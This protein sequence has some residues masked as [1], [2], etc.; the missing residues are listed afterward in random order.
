MALRLYGRGRVVTFV[1]DALERDGVPERQVLPTLLLSGQHGSGGSAL[2]RRLGDEFG[3]DTLCAHLDLAGAQGAGDAVLAAAHCLHR[4]IRW[5]RRVEFPRLRILI[6]ALSFVDE[7]GIRGDFESYLAAE[8]PGSRSTLHTWLGRALDLV[9]A[10]PEPHGDEDRPGA[11]PD[12]DPD[13]AAKS[14]DREKSGRDKA[15]AADLAQTAAWILAGVNHREDQ[16]ALHWFAHS[17]IAAHPEDAAATA[18]AAGYATLWRMLA[19]YHGADREH[20][21]E[22]DLALSAALLADLSESFNSR[23]FG[24][25]Q[26]RSNCLLLLDNADNETGGR[27]LRLL[28]EWRRT[29]PDPEGD[30][31][32]VV[33]VRRAEVP[34]LSATEIEATDERLAFPWD[35]AAKDPCLR[36]RLTDLS[37]GEVAE[38]TRSRVLDSAGHDARLVHDLTRGHPLATATLLA[39]LAHPDTTRADLPWLLD[40]NLPA[41]VGPAPAD[42]FGGHRV[43]VADYLFKRIFVDEIRVEGLEQDSNPLIAAMAVCAA[44]PG[45]PIGP[46]QVVIESVAEYY[47]QPAAAAA[48]PVDWTQVK[49][50]EALSRLE[51][52]G[53]AVGTGDGDGSVRLHPLPDLLLRDWLAGRPDTW[54]LVHEAYSAYYSRPETVALRQRHRLALAESTQAQQFTEVAAFLDGK[55]KKRSAKVGGLSEQEWL[56]LLKTVVAAPNRLFPEVNPRT[57]VA[58]VDTARLDARARVVARLTAA[59]WVNGDRRLDPGH[60]LA[61]VISDE[62]KNLAHMQMPDGETFFEQAYEWRRIAKEWEE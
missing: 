62:Y 13:R 8:G 28:G 12:P 23:A 15:R 56:N 49:G 22:V 9:A 53:W 61:Q 18:E 30:P 7:S 51:E 59:L 11:N 54:R 1:G 31:L 33:A 48:D 47:R 40:K 10:E 43:I 37:L 42:R 20:L 41:A 34:E 3:P 5:V 4:K 16:A 60:R 50:D 24:H 21:R 44:T 25:V 52:A 57:F 35:S 39:V 19:W 27:L 17:G 38:M 2:W 58:Q 36:I 46:S 26:R 6:K 14:R 55:L 45:L 29:R 32:L